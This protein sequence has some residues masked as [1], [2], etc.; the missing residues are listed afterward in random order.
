ME[1]STTSDLVAHTK[2]V[3]SLF[4]RLM[5]FALEG[6]FCSELRSV[7][8]GLGFNWTIPLPCK[9]KSDPVHVSSATSFD[10]TRSTMGRIGS[11]MS[12]VNPGRA[13]GV[14]LLSDEWVVKIVML[15]TPE[16]PAGMSDAV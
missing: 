6:R 11:I 13:A 10:I 9:S 16:D 7:C 1:T 4:T 5:E 8:A 14:S 2:G 3:R 15:P 12:I